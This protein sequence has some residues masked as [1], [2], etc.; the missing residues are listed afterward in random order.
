MTTSDRAASAGGR[1]QG[2]AGT[3]APY[4]SQGLVAV[5]TGASLDLVK[6]VAAIAMVAAHVNEVLLHN[7]WRP[8]WDFGRLAFPL[9]SF[10]V[11]AN[12]LRGAK[13]PA[14]VQ[15]FLLLGALAQPFYA[16]AFVTDQADTLFTLGVGATIGVFLR[17]LR[18][19]IQHAIFAGGIVAVFTPWIPA[20]AGVDGGIAGMLFPAAV[21]LVLDGGRTHIPSL[22]LLFVGLNLSHEMTPS[23]IVLTSLGAGILCLLVLLAAASFRRRSRILPRYAL[24]AFYPAHLLVLTLARAFG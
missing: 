8:L 16:A 17:P 6:I 22:L 20:Q 13:A 2:G 10:A 18:P 23:D 12:L 15:M 3:P 7:A 19:A 14:Y 11:A 4:D 5:F 24:Q 1:E 9:F 21:L